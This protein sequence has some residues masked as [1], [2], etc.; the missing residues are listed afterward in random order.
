VTIEKTE[1]P[2]NRK[3]KNQ[4]PKNQKTEFTQRDENRMFKVTT[5]TN[6]AR[7]PTPERN[8]IQ[9]KCAPRVIG[10]PVMGSR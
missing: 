2:K 6:P 4:K 8:P 10:Y 3:P 9:L 1:F 7:T 5:Q